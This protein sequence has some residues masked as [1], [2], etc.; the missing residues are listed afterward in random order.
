M[1]I[2]KNTAQKAAADTS[3]VKLWLVLMKAH[4]SMARHAQRS[5]EK[6]FGLSDFATLEILLNQGPQAVNEI[7]RRVQLT[8]GSITTAIDRLEE[9]GLV[10]RGPHPTDRRARVVELTKAGKALITKVFA[11]HRAALEHATG[12]LSATERSTLIELLK[13]LGTSADDHHH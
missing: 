3:G 8:S 1:T 4:R 6:H 9:R 12:S 13:K 2:R 7:G 5:V 11:A 10:A